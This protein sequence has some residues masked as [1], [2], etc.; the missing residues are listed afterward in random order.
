MPL[1]SIVAFQLLPI[2]TIAA[3]VTTYFNRKTGHVYVAA[4]TV[5]MLVT[6]IVVASTA[7]QFAF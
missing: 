6:W 2:M 3:L 1:Y 4:F 5:A 7:I